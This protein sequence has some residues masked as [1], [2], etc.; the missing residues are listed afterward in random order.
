MKY[1][2]QKENFWRN[3][4]WQPGEVF[5]GSNLDKV[6]RHFLC[7]HS[8]EELVHE[9]ELA[10]L[11]SD[12]DKAHIKYDESWGKKKLQEVMGSIVSTTNILT[13]RAPGPK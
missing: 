1:L 3:K 4:L 6:P 11:R 10:L 9:K 8:P 13:S 7:I 5:E 2:C 12:F